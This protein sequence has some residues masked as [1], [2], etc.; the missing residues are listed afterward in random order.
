MAHDDFDVIVYKALAYI[1]AC[2]KADVA[3]S[4]DKAQEVAGCGDV[5]WAMAVGSMLDDGL[6][7][8]ASVDSYYDGTTG[9][10]AGARLAITQKGARYLKEN[11]AMREAA[12]FLGKA[13][14]KALPV[15]IEA[16]RALMA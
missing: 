9:V 15:A 5:Y 10:S 7:R 11:S 8:G 6:I 1:M 13:F 14:D 3:P 12:R 4:I 16:T 2:A